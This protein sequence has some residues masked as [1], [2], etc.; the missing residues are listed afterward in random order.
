MARSLAVMTTAIDAAVLAEMEAAEEFYRDRLTAKVERPELPYPPVFLG[1]TWQQ[2]GD[3]WLLPERTLGWQMLAWTGAYLQKTREKPWVWT[4]EQ[5]RFLLHWYAVNEEGEFLYSDGVFQR[6]KGHGKDPL[7]AGIATFEL[8]GPCRV[9]DMVNGHPVGTPAAEPWVQVAAVSLEQTKNTMR[10]LP[11]LITDAAKRD[12]DLVVQKETVHGLHGQALMQAVTSSP[13]TLEGARASFVLLN[14]THH[15]LSNNSG[16]EMADVI[17]RNASKSEGGAARS[18]RITNA[19]EPGHDSVAER[20]REQA[21]AVLDGR[22]VDAGLL[23]DSLEA[24][25]DAPLTLEAAPDVIA[26]VRGDS[27]W[28]NVKRIAKSIADRRNPPSRS[29]RFWYNQIVAAEDAWVHPQKFDAL[30]AREEL[31]GG[32]TILVFFDGSKSDDATALVAARAKDGK[33]FQLGVWQKPPG[34]DEKTM[35]PWRVDRASVNARVTEVFETYRPVAFFAD[36][37]DT[38]DDESGERYWEALVD[39]WHRLYKRRLKLWAT[40]TG[41]KQHSV[42]W[43]MRSPTR[44]AE[45]TAAAERFVEDVDAGVLAHD[46]SRALRAHVKNARRA[47]GKYGI[48]LMKEHRESA[49]KIDLAVAAVGARMLWRLYNNKHAKTGASRGRVVAL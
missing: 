17:E 12:F 10:L 14:E 4:D 15:W 35:G 16:H 41:D 33:V 9:G 38:R 11:R 5:A 37:S 44:Q 43:D 46:A 8:A 24:P 36:P 23:Y 20:D 3:Y 6:L 47:P 31:A 19:Y 32:E 30:G 13:T 18:L 39:E 28:L 48:G 34:Y 45:F 29:R 1:P 26:S 40:K 2:D 25:P 27:V 21:E 49:R 42:N 22:A 7:G